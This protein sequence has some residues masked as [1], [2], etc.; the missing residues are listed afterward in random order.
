MPQNSEEAGADPSRLSFESAWTRRKI[1][2]SYWIAVILAIPLWWKI[3]SIDRL[4]LPGARVR[5]L[6]GKEVN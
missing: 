4:S 6:D 5:S 2:A 3:T 1:L